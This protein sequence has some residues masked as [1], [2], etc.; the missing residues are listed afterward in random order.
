MVGTL[1]GGSATCT[2]PINDYFAMFNKQWDFYKTADKQLKIWLDPNSSGVSEVPG[3]NPF[4][5]STSCAQFTNAEAG[6]KFTLQP[7]ANKSAGFKTGHNTIKITSYAER[8]GKTD[9]TLLSSVSIGVAKV[10]S[11]VFN[12]NSKIT[13]KVYNQDTKTGLPG[14]EIVTMELPYSLLSENKMNHIDLL[15]PVVIQN[16]YFIGYDINYLNAADT[17][18]VY[19]T[20]D[21]VQKSKNRAFAKT[22]GGWIPFYW[23]PEL[24]ISGSLLINANGCQNTLSVDDNPTIDEEAKF[25][26]LYPQTATTN[27]IMLRNKGT[28]EYGVISL[29]DILG[30]KFFT[31]E[32]MITST[33][34]EVSLMHYRSG[35]YF[36]SIETAN[37]R[38][39]IKIMVNNIK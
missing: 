18:A 25:E 33:P 39:V 31:E 21:R 32:R 17:F 22:S 6:E 7:L 27:Y 12:Q 23:I 19:M 4:D 10:S 28:E 26:V 9:Q 29:Y 35:V 16:N 8:F 34:Q 36:L 24:G 1:T 20:P 37:A 11:V 2:D 5:T 13:L 38:Q 14:T 3:L 30:R 15:N